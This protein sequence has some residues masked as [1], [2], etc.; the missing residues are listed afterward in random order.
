MLAVR[1]QWELCGTVATVDAI[2]SLLS[3][4]PWPPLYAVKFEQ[5]TRTSYPAYV[6]AVITRP[7]GD[8]R[9]DVVHLTNWLAQFRLFE[10]I[11][12]LIY[13]TDLELLSLSMET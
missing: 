4:A 5:V 9:I 3:S 1:I 6:T 11:D 8:R 2:K 12:T 13:L 10:E 7:Y